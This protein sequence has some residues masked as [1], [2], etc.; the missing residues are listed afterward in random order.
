[1]ES[2]SFHQ[3]ALLSN[4]CLYSTWINLCCFF[5]PSPSCYCYSSLQPLGMAAVTE[6]TDPWGCLLGP[7]HQMAG[8]GAT[9]R[10]PR[11]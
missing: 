3:E 2:S 5:L 1:M 9:Y 11:T 4:L 6:S 8:L 10:C 7:G